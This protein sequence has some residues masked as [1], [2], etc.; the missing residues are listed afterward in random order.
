[1][2]CMGNAAHS[3]FPAIQ[4]QNKGF[5]M[6]RYKVVLIFNVLFIFLIFSVAAAFPGVPYDGQA[7]ATGV[8]VAIQIPL[9]AAP[10]EIAISSRTYACVYGRRGRRYKCHRASRHTGWHH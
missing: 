4:V 10:I 5:I 9:V 2:A 6:K 8:D 3:S 1:M 7:E